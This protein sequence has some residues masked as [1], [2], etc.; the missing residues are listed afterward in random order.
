MYCTYVPTV[1]VLSNYLQ[2]LPTLCLLPIYN[3]GVRM[4]NIW[5]VIMFSAYYCASTSTDTYK[6]KLFTWFLC[7][8]FFYVFHVDIIVA[9]LFWRCTTVGIFIYIYVA[10]IYNLYIVV[11]Q[12]LF[13]FCIKCCIYVPTKSIQVCKFDKRWNMATRNVLVPTT[14]RLP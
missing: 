2:S 9:D 5:S 12:R 13:Y 8:A 1:H 6:L 14:K 3:Q 10:S 7:F 11:N 4:L